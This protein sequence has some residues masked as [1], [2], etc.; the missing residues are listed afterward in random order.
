[1]LLLKDCPVRTDWLGVLLLLSVIFLLRVD[2]DV[3][4]D[5]FFFF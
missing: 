3:V 4:N 1:M 2:V 5:F